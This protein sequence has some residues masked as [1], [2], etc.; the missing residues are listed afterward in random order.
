MTPSLKRDDAYVQKHLRKL[1]ADAARQGK[2]VVLVRN[3]RVEGFYNTEIEAAKAGF[4][5]FG[6]A[7][8]LVRAVSG[9]ARQRVIASNFSSE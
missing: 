1:A 7:P 8:F 2:S 4:S 5:R 3:K 9:E 6:D